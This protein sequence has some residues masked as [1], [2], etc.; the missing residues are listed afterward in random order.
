MT[1]ID[2]SYYDLYRNTLL[3]DK[4]VDLRFFENGNVAVARNFVNS[5]EIIA[6]IQR[7]DPLSYVYATEFGQTKIYSFN[8]G[9]I[10]D[11]LEIDSEFALNQDENPANISAFVGELENIL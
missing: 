11:F 4:D 6:V 1:E 5:L 2:L 8:T 3:T 10:L 7:K 9:E